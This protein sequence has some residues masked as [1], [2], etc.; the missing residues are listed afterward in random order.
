MTG[1]IGRSIALA[2][3]A[4]S[5]VRQ[6]RSLLAFPVLSLVFVMIAFALIIAPTVLLGAA[7]PLNG[8]VGEVAPYILLFIL[9][10]ICY[11]IA[12]FFNTALV[13]CADQH[14]RGIKPTVGEGLSNAIRHLPRIFAWALVGA[15]VGVVLQVIAQKGGVAGQVASSGIAALWSFITYFVL[16]LLVL[17]EKGVVEAITGSAALIRRTW[18]EAIVGGA[19]IGLV[20]LLLGLVALIP[21]GLA[22]LS[23]S[24]MIL[25][26]MGALAIVWWLVLGVVSSAMSGIYS[27]ALYRYAR[28]NE[29]QG[30]FDKASLASALV[31]KS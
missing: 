3:A 24:F 23:G 4:W 6:E 21:L 8:T 1:R 14:F 31:S 5:V 9:Y 28:F 12:I 19:S 22:F 16:P 27:V 20:F 18:G 26:I 30:S 29:V 7:L 17:E 25:T 10:L 2:K 13:T 11:M 15:T